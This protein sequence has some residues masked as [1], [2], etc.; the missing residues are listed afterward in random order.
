[1]YPVSRTTGEGRAELLTAWGAGFEQDGAGRGEGRG[2]GPA[3]QVNLC[4]NNINHF[5]G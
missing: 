1:M 3:G 4:V 2:G 5:R